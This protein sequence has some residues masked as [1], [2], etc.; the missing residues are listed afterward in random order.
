MSKTKRRKR[1]RQRR[2]AKWL[3]KARK[4]QARYDREL[5]H[6][7]LL[8]QFQDFIDREYRSGAM[9]LFRWT[10]DP[11]TADDFKPQIFQSFSDRDISE[12]PVPSPTGSD[13][14]IKSYVERFT[15]SHFLTEQQAIAKYR[16]QL[17][18]L[19][20]S[21]HPERVEGFK[22]K[23]GT[24]VQKCCYGEGDALY[25]KPGNGGHID[26]L[27]LRGLIPERVIDTTYTPVKIV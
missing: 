5:Q 26:I 15:L 4:I 3:K 16:E 14:K 6:S 27:P 2:K 19:Q 13:K 10:H 25:G 11:Y 21:D 17:D 20:N 7:E 23:K 12:V 9:S 1:A 22:E 18:I 24:Y 8:N